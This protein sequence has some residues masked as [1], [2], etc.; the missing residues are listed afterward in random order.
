VAYPD[1]HGASTEHERGGERDASR[2]PQRDCI[3]PADRTQ[4]HAR[5]IRFDDAPAR[6][7]EH[8]RADVAVDLERGERRCIDQPR[9]PGALDERAR[10]I[11]RG[12][13]RTQRLG[14][15]H[16][17]RLGRVGERRTKQSTFT[18]E[19][20]HIAGDA[21]DR[22]AGRSRD[23]PPRRRPEQVDEVQPIGL[24][25]ARVAPV[26]RRGDKPF[27]DRVFRHA[28]IVAGWV[29]SL[30]VTIRASLRRSRR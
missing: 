18:V 29:R 14:E 23:P 2:A 27:A 19:P 6:H 11:T 28:R 17:R 13:D 16:P 22:L 12:N 24:E 30:R 3:S 10:I 1:R 21:R 25:E 5:S 9:T 26:A 4:P 7:G 15:L 20:P 8:P